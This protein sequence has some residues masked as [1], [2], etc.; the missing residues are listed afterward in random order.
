MTLFFTMLIAGIAVGSVYALIATSYSIVFS[1]TQ[2]FNLAQGDLMVIGLMITYF[3]LE[4][5]HLPQWCACVFAV[6]GAVIL[7]LIEE[8]FVIR[9]FLKMGSAG[10]GWFIATLAITLIFESGETL[11]LGTNNLYPPLILSPFG[12][13]PL[14]IGSVGIAPYYIFAIVASIIVIFGVELFYKKTYVG[15]SMRA[16]SE[17]RELAAIRGISPERVSVIAFAFAGA[18]SGLAGY[19]LA[20]IA[21]L[22]ISVGL[23][24]GLL[25]FIAIAI[26]G[27]GNLPGALLG[28]WMIGIGQQAI[29]TYSNAN[30]DILAPVILLMLVLSIRPTGLFGSRN[31][32]TV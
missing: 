24:Y 5:W 9:R 6:A 27:F 30:Y 26:G 13:T 1:G 8:R 15:T 2:V 4:V 29:D 19:I 3:T 16:T 22:N 7:S 14:H 11:V 31:V 28:A 12:S 17:D 32:R 23:S 21:Q 10:F 20:P 25:A 18:I